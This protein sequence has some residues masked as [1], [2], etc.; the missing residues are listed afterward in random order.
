MHIICIYKCAYHK[1]IHKH[2]QS[3]WLTIKGVPVFLWSSGY[4]DTADH[5]AAL[6]NSQ[7]LETQWTHKP[8]KPES[9]SLLQSSYTGPQH[10]SS[11]ESENNLEIDP[12]IHNPQGTPA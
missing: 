7:G 5:A 10:V 6:S 8:S 9:T 12:S 4:N 2:L 1:D 11:L 3:L